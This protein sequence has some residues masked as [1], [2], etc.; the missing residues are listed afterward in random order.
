MPMLTVIC[1]RPPN[2]RLHPE[3]QTGEERL[4]LGLAKMRE[5]DLRLART[6]ERARGIKR[7]ARNA[8][9]QAERA[10]GIDAGADVRLHCGDGL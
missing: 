5:L 3:A 7:S 2:P 1:L 10:A 9:E 4:M 6:T 8:A